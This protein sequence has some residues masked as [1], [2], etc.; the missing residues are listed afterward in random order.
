MVGWI[1]EDNR[2]N[3]W[4]VKIES[5]THVHAGHIHIHTTV[6]NFSPR[7]W[8]HC[9]LKPLLGSCHPD[10]ERERERERKKS[11]SIFLTTY[12]FCQITH[13][14]CQPPL[15]LSHSL[16]VH[17]LKI[18][19]KIHIIELVVHYAMWLWM[20]TI[21]IEKT[22]K[23]K[24]DWIS[25][26]QRLHTCSCHITFTIWHKRFNNIQTLVC[27]IHSICTDRMQ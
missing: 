4:H 14:L 23:S 8:K 2:E 6:I 11:N 22:G 15:W 12:I 1:P 26:L 16:N 20:K 18:F 25:C 10:L 5:F 21:W 9:C 24:F 7:P 27:I 19:L 13:R 17:H 3:Q